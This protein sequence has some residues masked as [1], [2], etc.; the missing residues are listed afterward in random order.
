MHSHQPRT[1]DQMLIQLILL[2]LFMAPQQEV[3]PYHSESSSW[4][5]DSLTVY[6]FLNDEC[7]ISQFYTPELTRLF[8][9]YHSQKVGF[10]GYF[11]SPS[12][13]PDRI[14]KFGEAYR[15][16]F[17]LEGDYHKDQARRLGVTVTPEVA[18]WD[19]RSD[20][21]IYRGRIDDSYVRVGK[22]K[23]H[24]QHYDLQE[25]IDSWLAGQGSAEL[26]QTQAIGCFI[27]FTD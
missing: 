2:S 7:V 3:K 12:S 25:I 18:V 13:T 11:P 6:I 22:R 17:P 10:T 5:G 1:F 8:D 20:R 4:T 9:T 26:E 15:L 19:H 14:Q 27:S 24:P 21:L 23:L 16:A